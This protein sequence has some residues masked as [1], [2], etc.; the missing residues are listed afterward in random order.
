MNIP[1]LVICYNNHEY[2]E[3]T[4]NQIRLI[5]KEYYNNIQIVDNCSTCPDTIHFL[6]NVSCKVIYNESNNGPRIN[7][8]SNA[9]IYNSLPDKFIFTDPDL[10]FNPKL[11]F[12]F[13]EVLSDLSDKYN[14]SRIGFALD[15]SDPDKMFQTEYAQTK[16]IYDWEKQ[17]WEEKVE[18][19]NYELYLAAIDT[20]FGLLNK[21]KC[22]C[23]DIHI[24][25]AGDFTAKHL[26]WYKD[27]K[28]LNTYKNYKACKKT[29]YISTTS[30]VI[31]HHIDNTFIKI[32]KNNEFF[33]IEKNQTNENLPFWENLYSDWKNE[34]FAIFDKF[35][36]KNKTFID[37]GGW[38]GT[39]CMYG[40]RYSKHVY[41]IEADKKSFDDMVVNCKHNCDV[42]NH[43]LINKT[44]YNIDDVEINS[45]SSKKNVSTSVRTITLQSIID[46]NNINPKDISLIKVDI[47]GGEE[48]ILNDLFKFHETF[49]TPMYLSFHYDCWKDKNLD[50]FGFLSDTIKQNIEKNPFISILFE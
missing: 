19:T 40:S 32:N 37:I 25:V 3:N 15:I 43:T 22:N 46:N 9:H 28:I 44:I 39:T 18:D 14:A 29:T 1:I 24:R 34:T 31:L 48:A 27:N 23:D 50:R 6:K 13:I 33:F 17:Y 5:N 35:L 26:P 49:T 41:A 7:L 45:I 36:D 38:I 42:D 12:N 20:T 30:Q 2:V 4:M 16:N 21:K 47:D 8:N 11:P 10:G